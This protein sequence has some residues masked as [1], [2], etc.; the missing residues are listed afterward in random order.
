MSVALIATEEVR[1][2]LAAED[3]PRTAAWLAED[4]AV[5]HFAVRRHLQVLINRGQV[6]GMW[7]HGR[8]V[9]YSLTDAGRAASEAN[10]GL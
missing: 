3:G 4:L 1:D 2:T 10:E 8:A 6:R 5:S 9:V 7:G